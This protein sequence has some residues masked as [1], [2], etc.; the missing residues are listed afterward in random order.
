MMCRRRV[1]ITLTGLQA[2]PQLRQDIFG[3]WE[4]ERRFRNGQLM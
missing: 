4:K 1:L 2:T 3:D